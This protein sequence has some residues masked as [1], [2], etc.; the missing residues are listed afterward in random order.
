[1]KKNKI[2][3]AILAVSAALASPHA[4]AQFGGLISALVGGG[5]SSS[6]PNPDEFLKSALT[7][8]KLMNNSV[9][10]M[11]TSLSTKEKSAEL[12]AARA[13]ANA[14][15]DPAEKQAKKLEVQKSEQAALAQALADSNVDQKVKAMDVKQKGELAAAS[16]NFMLALLQDK[17]LVGQASS[18]ISSI[19]SNPM[20]LTKIG[21]IKDVAS[22]LG[23]QISDASKVAGKM[24]AIFSAVGIQP[25]TSKDEKPKE[26]KQVEGE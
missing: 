16:F 18:L 5:G 10:L 9:V 22:S 25:P 17:A 12:V 15:T 26:M 3:I 21:S 24:P 4:V 7:A 13:A 8:E 11:A 14:M 19:S 2:A 23:N 6:A 20:N 1:M